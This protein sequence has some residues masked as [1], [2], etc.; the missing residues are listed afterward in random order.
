MTDPTPTVYHVLRPGKQSVYC[1]ATLTEGVTYYA[2]MMKAILASLRPQDPSPCPK[3]ME[4]TRAPEHADL[5]TLI[6]EAGLSSVTLTRDRLATRDEWKADITHDRVSYT[7]RG[8]NPEEALV[9]AIVDRYIGDYYYFGD[10]DTPRLTPEQ[11]TDRLHTAYRLNLG[12]TPDHAYRG[13]YLRP[14]DKS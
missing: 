8:D 9:E 3:C 10:W 6:E 5:D 2:N 12:F 13:S 4:V 14:E 7:G 11:M 1:G